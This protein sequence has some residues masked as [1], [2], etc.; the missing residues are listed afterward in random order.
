MSVVTSDTDAEWTVDELARRT[1]VPVRTIREYQTMGLLHPPRRSGR[2]GLYDISHMRRLEL[3][4]RLQ[5]RGY[6]LAGINDL[7]TAWRQGAAIADVLGLE[8]D[9]LVHVDEPGVPAAEATLAHI[10]PTLVPDHLEQL[11]GTGI[12]EDCG[13][14]RYCIP[15]PSL[16][17]L[18]VD[19]IAAGVPEHSVLELLGQIRRAADTV[20][21]AVLATLADL[22]AGTPG[23][24]IEALA[25]KGRGLLSHGVGRLT[26]HRLGRRLEIDDDATTEQM[27]QRIRGLVRPAARSS[28]KTKRSGRR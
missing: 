4:G 6:S 27:A 9:Q 15:S 17:Q 1:E 5:E 23:D 14:D 28:R 26:L 12:I 10:L 8:P 13:P 25:S 7:L 11:I 2:I 18:T 22:P 16:L 19:M 21:D 24:D 3:I 20:T